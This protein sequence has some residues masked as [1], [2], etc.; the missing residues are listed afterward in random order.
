[1]VL[2][3][4]QEQAVTLDLYL[5]RLSVS[6]NLSVNRTMNIIYR[7]GERAIRKKKKKFVSVFPRAFSVIPYGL[8]AAIKGMRG[9]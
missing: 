8:T 4:T 7:S 1:M 3:H 2:R 6:D 9:L 5:H